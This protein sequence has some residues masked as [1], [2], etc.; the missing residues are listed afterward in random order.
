MLL[1]S[2]RLREPERLLQ[3]SK[4]GLRCGATAAKAES[5]AGGSTAPQGPPRGA[6][7]AAAPRRPPLTSYQLGH[8]P[9]PA[10]DLGR[11]H[12]EV[13][14]VTLEIGGHGGGGAGGGDSGPAALTAEKAALSW[15]PSAAPHPGASAFCS[16]QSRFPPASGRLDTGSGESLHPRSGAF[17]QRGPPPRSR[18][19][20]P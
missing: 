1:G 10:R 16:L 3:P 15:P 9:D 5:S 6:G 13:L 11:K 2:R 20:T 17:K 8:L 7:P 12:R 18:P 4:T 14:L 19:D